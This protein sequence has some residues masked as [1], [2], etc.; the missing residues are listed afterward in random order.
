MIRKIEITDL[1][2]IKEIII[3]EKVSDEIES[4]KNLDMNYDKAVETVKYWIL[5]KDS[6]VFLDEEDGEITGFIFGAV[7]SPWCANDKHAVEYI[8]YVRKQFRGKKIATNLL[9]EFN[10]AAINAGCK[11]IHT[12]I[13]VSNSNSR[14]RLRILTKLGYETSMFYL[15]KV[16]N[17]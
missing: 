16:I 13:V 4:F 5:S 12:G 15:K 9:K 1:E 11:E 17:E 6:L 10:N 14:I 3:S 8:L 7:Y 2:R